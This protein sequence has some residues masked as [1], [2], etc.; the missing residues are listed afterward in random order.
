[1]VFSF[2]L[3]YWRIILPALAVIGLMMALWGWG[4]YKYNEGYKASQAA[5]EKALFEAQQKAQFEIRKVQDEYS[6]KKANIPAQDS[7]YGVGNITRNVINGL[8]DGSR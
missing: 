6:K 7:G 1:M 4:R 3:K 5:Y 2:F 8:P